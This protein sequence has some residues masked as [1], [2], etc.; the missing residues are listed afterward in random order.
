[1]ALGDKRKLF[2]PILL[3]SCLFG[4]KFFVDD[5]FRFPVKSLV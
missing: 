1:M 3:K 5:K 2:L 4:F